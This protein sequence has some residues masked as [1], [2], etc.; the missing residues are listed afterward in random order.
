VKG[1]G[2]PQVK[3]PPGNWF[4]PL[5]SNRSGGGGNEAVGAS[6]VESRLA[7][8]QSSDDGI[9]TWKFFAV[10]KDHKSI[11]FRAFTSSCAVS[12]PIVGAEATVVRVSVIAE[13]GLENGIQVL[14]VVLGAFGAEMESGARS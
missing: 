2:L 7:E 6:D 11:E 4:A 12:T 13:P 9:F 3:V 5:G 14:E 8:L 10:Q 1:A